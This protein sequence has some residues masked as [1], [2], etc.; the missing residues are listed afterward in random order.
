MAHPQLPDFGQIM[1][2][3]QQVASQIEP[4][5]EFKSG[6]SLSEEEMTSAI[7]KITKSVSEVV[8][9]EMLSG[10]SSKKQGKQ[11]AVSA[12]V[13][14]PESSKISLNDEETDTSKSKKTKKKRIVEIESE[15]SDDNDPIA[16]R[17]K[18]MSFTLSVSLEE[19]YMGT[20][21]KLALRRQKN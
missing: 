8:K 9:P 11:R 19:L 17:T 13:L 14:K 21:K 3:A 18:D 2:L 15:D 6:K 1:K 10:M 4:P 5:A 7:S 20:K 12:P 16:P